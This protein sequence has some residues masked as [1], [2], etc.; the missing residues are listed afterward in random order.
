MKKIL[1]SLLAIT[2]SAFLAAQTPQAINYQAI[3]RDND[4]NP[5]VNA[6][7][8]IQFKILQGELSDR[9]AYAETFEATTN[10]GG[11]FNLQIGRGSRLSATSHK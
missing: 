5:I 3:A 1:L 2:A 4:G 6:S 11:L 8:S 10:F 7:I 9:V